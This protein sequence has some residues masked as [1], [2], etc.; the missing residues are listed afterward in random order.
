MLK[1]ISRVKHDQKLQ[2]NLNQKV[3]K[4]N[5]CYMF[6]KMINL[7]EFLKIHKE[8][9]FVIINKIQY[10]IQSI[11]SIHL[12]EINNK[13][14]LIIWKEDIHEVYYENIKYLLNIGNFRFSLKLKSQFIFFSSKITSF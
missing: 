8:N 9:A 2:I 4:F 13:R 1:I 6:V 3:I 10:V 14:N 7:D 12:G 5:A 11:A